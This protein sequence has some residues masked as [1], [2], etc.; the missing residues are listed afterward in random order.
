MDEFPKKIIK[1]T[2]ALIII[3]FLLITAG[4]CIGYYNTYIDTEIKELRPE[5]LMKT[6][7]KMVDG[8]I[9]DVRKYGENQIIVQYENKDSDEWGLSITEIRKNGRSQTTGETLADTYV[10][11]TYRND[12]S[13]LIVIAG[14]ECNSKIHSYKLISENGEIIFEKI[15]DERTFID[16]YERTETNAYEILE[17]R[18]YDIHGNDITEEIFEI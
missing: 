15:I 8:D 18:Y 13:S 1:I 2:A 14:K 5:N 9:I 17:T 4:A 7:Q 3:G 11:Q 6:A 12:E 16:I 10:L